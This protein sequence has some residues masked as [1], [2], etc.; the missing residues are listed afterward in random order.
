MS[1]RKARKLENT[2]ALYGLFADDPVACAHMLANLEEAF[3]P[4]CDWYGI[5]EGDQIDATV[6]VYTAYRIPLVTTYGQAGGVEEGL[7][8]FHD[9]LP[10][11]AVVHIQW[12]SLQLEGTTPI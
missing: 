1:E 12:C 4:Y 9:E 3:A 5:G 7:S 6:L 2:E 11:R 8:A 10:D